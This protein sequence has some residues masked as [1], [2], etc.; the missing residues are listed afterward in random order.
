[1]ATLSVL[2]TFANPYAFRQLPAAFKILYSPVAFEHFADMSSMS[3]RHPQ[4]YALMLLVMF[5]FLS[6]GR[7]R[8]IELFE[9]MTLVVGTLV[10]FRIERD[11]WL[12][13]LPALAVL[14]GGLRSSRGEEPEPAR[15]A[16]RQPAWAI[17]A[18]V[19]V[20]TLSVLFFVPRS[21]VLV[22]RVSQTLPVRACDYIRA[23]HLP[24]PLFN[25]YSWGSFLTW[26]LPEYPVVIDNRV[27]L[28]G[29]EILS[30]YFDVIGG[31]ELLES[32]PTVS[33]AGTLLLE[34][35]SAMAR[36]LIKLPAL[37][38]QYRLV[39]SDEIASVY[40]PK[41]APVE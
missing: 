22:E 11:G 26:Y 25:A 12:A 35:D 41:N 31:K 36:A 27:E 2:A 29:D 15:D 7:R 34:R 39:Y 10:A 3:F 19:A 13:V 32:E 40:V 14:S 4:E 17:A 38:A 21:N 1:V 33:R 6:L 5:A 8:S 28:Y 37:S 24:Q 16:R 30:K 20:V 9:W 18:T 23:N